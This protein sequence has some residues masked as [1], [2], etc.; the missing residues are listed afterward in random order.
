MVKLL[1]S[2]AARMFS[3]REFNRRRGWKEIA[4]FG[5]NIHLD[6]SETEN[7]IKHIQLL[8]LCYTSEP[9]PEA[10]FWFFCLVFALKSIQTRQSKSFIL[11]MMWNQYNWTSTNSNI[12]NQNWSRIQLLTQLVGNRNRWKQIVQLLFFLSLS[13]WNKL[14]VIECVCVYAC[15][16]VCVHLIFSLTAFKCTP[17]ATRFL[18]SFWMWC[19][20]FNV[21]NWSVSICGFRP[22][23]IM[24]E[25]YFYINGSNSDRFFF[26]LLPPLSRNRDG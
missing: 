24:C 20:K 6:F 13:N 18:F 25:N 26:R 17:N 1:V 14:N 22:N 4:K 8:N 7:E 21:F 5:L 16:Y 2:V 3:I 11:K 9:T 23:I 12:Q 15:K 19:R 10:S